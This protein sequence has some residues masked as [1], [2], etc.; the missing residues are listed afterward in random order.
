MRLKKL[1]RFI[2]SSFT[3][4]LVL[5]FSIVLF[6]MVM[7]FLWKYVDDMAGKGLEFGVLMELLFYFA[8]TFIP[9]ALP[10]AILLASLMTFGNLGENLELTAMK[11]AGISLQRLMMP[12]LIIVILFGIASFY[13]SDRVL[14]VASRKSRTLLMDITEKRP[15]LNIPA[16]TFYN[17]ITDIS[18][19]ISHIDPD[20]Q[21]LEDILI[22]DHRAK[23]GNI[24]VTYADSGYMKMTPDKSALIFTLYNGYS[25]LE[26]KEMD[27]R[28][29][30]TRPHRK[31]EFRE[32][33]LLLKLDG[34]DLMRTDEESMSN[35]SWAMNMDQLEYYIDSLT[36]KLIDYKSY[37]GKQLQRNYIFTQYNRVPVPDSTIKKTFKLDS[38]YQSLSFSDRA[39]ALRMAKTNLWSARKFA[40]TTTNSVKNRRK[41]IRRY[42]N[43]WH[44]KLTLSFACLVFFF[45]GAPLGAIIRKGGLGTPVVISVLFFVFYYIISLAGEKL[46]R[47]TVLSAFSGMWLSSLILLPIGVFLTWKA[48]RDS[49]LLNTETYSLFFKK[50]FRGRSKTAN[51]KGH[52]STTDQ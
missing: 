4:P 7:Q 6:I 47:E 37:F 14:P 48:T 26:I 39:E 29:S 2:I 11:S 9:L 40:T 3:G 23:K 49:T 24:A 28:Q 25:Y 5:T 51:L 33:Q 35:R 10:L 12:L 15:E 13:F 21:A 16:G 41:S 19:K 45:I 42:E 17:D 52:A 43:D 36:T 34:F 27:D 20:T 30:Q 8:L 22:Y 44:K 50:L 32:Q 31:D 1:H 38:I 18:L 46:A